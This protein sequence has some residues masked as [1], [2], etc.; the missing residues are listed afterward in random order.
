ME[1]FASVVLDDEETI[2]DSEREGRHGEEVHGRDYFAVIAQES[3]PKLPCLLG[4]RQAPD[5][6][7]HCAFR[8]V[9]AEFEKFT[10]NPRSAP[11]GILLHYPPDESSNLG[12]G[13]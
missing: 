11:G 5:V 6:A 10:V 2:Q 1:K 4:R 8:D 12:I 9:E 7:R 13:L 3:S